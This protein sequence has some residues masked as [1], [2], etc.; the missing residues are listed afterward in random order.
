MMFILIVLVR[1]CR[2]GQSSPLPQLFRASQ[3]RKQPPKGA[4][5]SALALPPPSL[6]RGV[7]G[8]TREWLG[9]Q[10]A[11]D[12]TPGLPTCYQ[13]CDPGQFIHLLSFIPS[14]KWEKHKDPPS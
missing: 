2:E 14:L 9:V 8:R 10:E 5:G 4:E 13:S 1:P 11:W 12:P 3:K 6:E 7:S